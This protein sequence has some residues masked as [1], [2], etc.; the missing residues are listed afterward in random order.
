M[1]TNDN[2][3]DTLSGYK[4]QLL[5]G[6][7]SLVFERLYEY[8][9]ERPYLKGLTDRLDSLCDN[10]H[11]MMDYYS[12]GS[13]DPRR[14]EY[15]KCYRQET[16]RLVQDILMAECLRNDEVL[17]S[18]AGS[19][20]K[21]AGLAFER[22]S[23]LPDELNRQ[24]ADSN[25]KPEEFTSRELQEYEQQKV[26]ANKYL[27]SS[28]LFSPQWDDETEDDYISII[29]E[30]DEITSQVMVSAIMLS[31]QLVFDIRKVRALFRIYREA[32]SVSVRERAFVGAIFSLNDD[33]VFWDEEQKELVQK[34]CSSKEDVQRVLDFQKQVIYLVDTEKDTKEARK[35]FNIT[36]IMERNPGLKE[37][38]RNESID[39]DSLEEYISPEEEEELFERFDEGMKRYAEMEKEGSDLYYKG[40]CLMKDFE[41]FSSITNWF[42]PFYA[43]NPVLAP[44]I[45]FMNGDSRFVK[46]LEKGMPFCSSDTYSF[47]LVLTQL[48]QQVPLIRQLMNPNTFKPKEEPDNNEMTSASLCRRKYLQDVYRFFML[49]PMKGSFF[50]LFDNSFSGRL[51]FLSK[52]FFD[53]KQY[54]EAHLSICRFLARRKD[55]KRLNYFLQQ[56]MPVTKEYRLMKA[57]VYLDSCHDKDR[58]LQ[59]L[60]PLLAKEPDCLPAQKLLAKCYYQN[61]CYEEAI[62]P[63]RKLLEAYPGHV[64]LER[65]IAVCLTEIGDYDSALEVLFRLDYLHPGDKETMRELA[66]TLFL[67]GS[68]TKALRYYEKIL[69]KAS[70]PSKD[71]AMDICNEAICK[72]AVGDIAGAIQGFAQ[73]LMF[74]DTDI[75]YDKFYM[76]RDALQQHYHLG[77]DDLIL[78][79]DAAYLA[80]LKLQEQSN[81]NDSQKDN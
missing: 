45:E 59:L 52:Q 38:A 39:M 65:R 6:Q 30:Y 11:R 54:E 71:T 68:A 35:A 78:M 8:I 36:D 66:R 33:E 72:W 19:S 34:F 5:N 9:E 81:A 75:L 62:A 12:K 18:L 1:A 4:Y 17:A 48:S 27:F 55:Y 76:F 23:D 79:I 67:K 15:F 77:K 3:S 63:Y 10:Y 31:T 2:Y 58:V 21:N 28:I 14:M 29:L 57:A 53:V 64:G 49:A 60:K 43:K 25:G 73:S 20:S 37:L 61:G 51:A 7:L 46:N 40:F 26:E 13:E 32:N 24:M 42:T 44:L 41:F 47:T 50:P 80:S 16:A 69:S 22:N 74:N 70:K 56:T